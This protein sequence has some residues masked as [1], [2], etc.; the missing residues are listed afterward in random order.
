MTDEQQVAECVKCHKRKAKAD[1]VYIWG[2][3]TYCCKDCCGDPA[4]GDH[5]QKVENACEF[6]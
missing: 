3:T 4:K 2:G 5:K 6:C 1:G